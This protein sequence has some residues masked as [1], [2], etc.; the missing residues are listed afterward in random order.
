MRLKAA[1]HPILQNQY[2]ALTQALIRIWADL[3]VEVEV[4]TKTMPE[5]L[6]AWHGRRDIDLWL[7]RW[8]A[9]YDD[10]DNFTFT[11]FHSGNGRLRSY[12]SS[13][14]ADRILEEARAEARPAARES[15][16]RKFEHLL[17]DSAI[18][19]PLFHDVDY[20]IGGPAVRGLQLHST[21][22]YVNYAEVGKDRG[23]RGAGGSRP[24]GWRRDPARADRRR[25][26]KPRPGAGRR[27]SNRPRSFHRSS[28][29]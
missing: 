8:I 14:E 4:A 21:A 19:V 26:A 15:L 16:Y 9:D 10:P 29:P 12:F 22:P 11:L 2:A 23:A 27:R 7:G 5:F 20:R 3:G 6:E 13:P 25:R 18:L 1:V 17:L 28:R 24:A